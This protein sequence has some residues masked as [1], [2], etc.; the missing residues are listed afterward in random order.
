MESTET[1]KDD[2]PDSSINTNSNEAPLVTGSLW[3]A[4]WIMSWPLLLTTVANSL[5]GMTDLYVA[6][7]LGSISQAAVGLSEQIIFMFLL[8]IMATGTGTT[9]LVAR[10][11]GE[12]DREKAFKY[13]AQSLIMAVM[14]GAGLALASS[15]GAH[16]ALAP[17]TK[18]PE[19]TGLCTIYLGIFSLYMVPFSVVCITNAAFRAIGDAKTP[20]AIVSTFTSLSIL[21]D[22]L[23]VMN[24]WPIAGLGIR[25][26]AYSALTASTIAATLALYKLSRSELAPSL[27]MVNQVIPEMIRRI[28]KIGIPSALQRMAWATSTFVLFFILARCPMPT[29]S[30]AS[31]TIGMRVEGLM[32]MPVMALSMAVS[33]IVGQN[34][35]A[36]EIERAYKAG[37]QVAWIGIG[38][39]TVMAAVLFLSATFIANAFSKDPTTIA[40]VISYL[41]VNSLSEPFLA[42]GMILGG[43]FQGAGDTKTPMWITFMTNWVIRLPLAYF[44]AL[45]L[46]LGPTGAWWAMTLSVVIM[47][48]LTAWR[49]RSRSWT[50]LH[51]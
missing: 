39:L 42:L 24:N 34:L 51:V 1:A 9:A 31:W 32:F 22:I 23:L 14:M 6:G 48:F 30:L 19:V 41:R 26:I 46:E 36:R 15:L 37:W 18:S 17:F 27:K 21:G 38:L 49:F 43:A 11:W 33:S 44:L 5:V 13:T 12:G 2:M 40:Y 7:K 3:R 45:H 25:G 4:I 8:F 35:G 28:V 29:E 47:G 10:H 50:E 16:F 20:L